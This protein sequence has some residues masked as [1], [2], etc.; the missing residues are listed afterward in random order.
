MRGGIEERRGCFVV[1]KSH[2]EIFW[3]AYVADPR[4]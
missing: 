2:V 1:L 3:L 4:N